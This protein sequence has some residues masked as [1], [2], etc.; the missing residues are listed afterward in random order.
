[1]HL[2]VYDKQNENRQARS[3]LGNLGVPNF[4]MQKQERFLN[5]PMQRL[6]SH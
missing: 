6:L 3:D 1:M 4:V 5:N 2:V